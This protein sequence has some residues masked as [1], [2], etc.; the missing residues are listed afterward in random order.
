MNAQ[1]TTSGR[2]FWF[3]VGFF[4]VSVA[5]AL[6]DAPLRYLPDLRGFERTLGPLTA[7]LGV[8]IS[9]VLGIRFR[10]RRFWLI[11]I[12][13]SMLLGFWGWRICREVHA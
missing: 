6:L 10:E 5:C 11:F 12:T 2:A 9:V 7:L 1:E 4:G 8:C 13:F 3:L